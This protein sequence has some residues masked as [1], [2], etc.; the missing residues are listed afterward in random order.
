MKFKVYTL[1]GDEIKPGDRITSFRGEEFEF[2]DCIHPRK[3]TVKHHPNSDW[4][5]ELFPTVFN[6]NIKE[7]DEAQ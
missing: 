2:V 3:I 1:A 6:L 4:V 5:R 7:Q